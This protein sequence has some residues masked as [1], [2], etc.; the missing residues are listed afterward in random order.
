MYIRLNFRSKRGFI[1]NPD[2][3]MDLGIF[4]PSFLLHD[5]VFV[6]EVPLRTPN[7]QK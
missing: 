5:R 7:P 6:M 3:L 2:Y 4:A 1:F